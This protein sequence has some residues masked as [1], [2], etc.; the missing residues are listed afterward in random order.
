MKKRIL[1]LGLA[2]TAVFT[3]SGCGGSGSNT[4]GNPGSTTVGGGNQTP[5]TLY[6]AYSPVSTATSIINDQLWKTDGTPANTSLVSNTMSIQSPTQD[7][8]L[9]IFEVYKIGNNVFTWANYIHDASFPNLPSGYNKLYKTDLSNGDATTEVSGI[10]RDIATNLVSSGGIKHFTASNGKTYLLNDHGAPTHLSIVDSNGGVTDLPNPPGMYLEPFFSGYMQDGD[11]LYIIAKNTSSMQHK[12]YKIDLSS[13]SPSWVEIVSSPNRLV[14]LYVHNSRL[15]TLK[16]NGTAAIFQKTSATP[17]STLTPIAGNYTSYWNHEASKHNHPYLI[18]GS[19]IYLAMRISGN[20]ANGGLYSIDTV[21]NDQL[22]YEGGTVSD[23]G[24]CVSLVK[25]NGVIYYLGSVAFDLK[26]YKITN[27]TVTHIA[28]IPSYIDASHEIWNRL[29]KAN[30]K[31][32]F[33][34][35]DAQHGVELWSYNGT[36]LHRET[37]INPGTGDSKPTRVTELNGKIVFQATPDG[38]NNKLYSLDGTTLTSLN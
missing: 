21:N 24:G 23:M 18:D 29:Y 37:D 27:N 2:I 10:S 4:G 22:H 36:T 12:I 19:K 15:Y 6:L 5:Q 26:L 33:A 7:E 1:T 9:S 31:L 14:D 38:T 17:N 11:D 13:N 25:L 8:S 35:S 30:G 16:D 20:T 34:K 3:I 28:T 32:Y